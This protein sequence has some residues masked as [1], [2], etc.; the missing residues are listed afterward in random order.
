YTDLSKPYENFYHTLYLG[1]NYFIPGAKSGK[2]TEDFIDL[3]NDPEQF[4]FSMY[5]YFYNTLGKKKL[6]HNLK[7][8]YFTKE[9]SFGGFDSVVEY[10][11]ND[12]IS[13]RNEAEYSGVDNRFDKVFSEALF[14]YGEWKLSLNHAYRIYENEKYN[15]LGTKAQYNI[16][17]NYQI[18]G[19]L[20]FDLNKDPE[21]WEVGYTYQRKCWN[22]SLMYRKDI[23][24]KLTSGGISAKDQSGVYFMFNFYPLGGVSYD[25]SLEENERSI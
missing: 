24:P 23:S 4:N 17:S 25:F 3:K 7:A 14:D 16:N 12:Y 10:F 13:L 6:Y 8:K 11:Y 5:Q 19:G 1:V 15:F 22:Y 9:G 2:I 20:W 21:K 18:F